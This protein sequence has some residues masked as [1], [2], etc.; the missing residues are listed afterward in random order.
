MKYPQVTICAI[1]CL[2]ALE[3]VALLNGINGTVLRMVTIMIALCAG[4]IIPTPK[5]FK[6]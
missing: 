2:T 5:V 1:I 4:V 3:I 6:E